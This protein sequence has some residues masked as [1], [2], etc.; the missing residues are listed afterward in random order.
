MKMQARQEAAALPVL[1]I[2]PAAPACDIRRILGAQGLFW[3]TP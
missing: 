1:A 3:E 2:G